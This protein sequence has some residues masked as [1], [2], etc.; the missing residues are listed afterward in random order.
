M[1]TEGG[2]PP[3]PKNPPSLHRLPAASRSPVKPLTRPRCHAFC[4]EE[5][6]KARQRYS[7]ASRAPVG[8]YRHTPQ[9]EHRK[10]A[11]PLSHA[12]CPHRR[13]GSKKRAFAAFAAL[14]RQAARPTAAC[15]PSAPE[16]PPL[17]ARPA[18]QAR[19]QADSRKQSGRAS[20][21]KTAAEYRRRP[22]LR[23]AAN[24]STAHGAGP[25]LPCLLACCLAP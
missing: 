15:T 25:L 1:S 7:A 18:K 6:Q 5:E 23:I 12:F 22:L 16:R 17:D 2:P 11:R 19:S 4:Q 24:R 8:A 13:Q 3:A 21:A 20:V 10:P 9:Q 14:R